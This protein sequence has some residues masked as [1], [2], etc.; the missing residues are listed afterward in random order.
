MSDQFHAP[1]ALFPGKDFSVTTEWSDPNAKPK[2]QIVAPAGTQASSV[3]CGTR[4]S[5]AGF[6]TAVF[7]PVHS[8]MDP[9]HTFPLHFC[10]IH[11]NYRPTHTQ[12]K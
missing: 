10:K 7:V 6:S 11:F 12:F 4:I 8:H 3:F 9:P 2:T 5:T 1:A